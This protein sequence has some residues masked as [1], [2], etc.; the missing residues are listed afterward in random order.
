M[1][2]PAHLFHLQLRVRR[3]ESGHEALALR[4]AC[5]PSDVIGYKRR[6]AVGVAYREVGVG[7]ICVRGDYERKRNARLTGGVG[8]RNGG[9]VGH[10]AIG[11]FPS[12]AII[13]S[14][15]GNGSCAFWV[16]N[17]RRCGPCRACGLVFFCADLYW[18]PR[19]RGNGHRT[20]A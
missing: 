18:E 17:V 14:W 4:D 5:P 13:C 9:F 7:W 3:T 20:C 1:A 2:A 19:R 12:L 16:R 10:R 8:R 15:E 6:L 11:R